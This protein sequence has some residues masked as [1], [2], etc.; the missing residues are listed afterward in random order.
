[1][2]KILSTLI[3]ILVYNNVFATVRT[4]SN[5]SN[6]LGQ[7]PSLTTAIGASL[8]GDTIYLSGSPLLYSAS[9][10]AKNVTIIGTGFNP[11]KQNPIVS[12]IGTISI[13]TGIVKFLGLEIDSLKFT[14]ATG[15][16][17]VH[18]SLL[19]N[20]YFV[21]DNRIKIFGSVI[22]NSFILNSNA[23]ECDIYTSVI[24]PQ[25][26]LINTSNATFDVYNSLFLFNGK[27]VAATGVYKSSNDYKS[28]IFYGAIPE[29]DG[30]T[31]NLVGQGDFRYN[32]SY[33]NSFTDDDGNNIVANP[34]FVNVASPPLAFNFNHNFHLQA[35]SPALLN[36]DINGNQ[37]GIYS[38]FWADY[39]YRDNGIPPIPSI[40]TMSITPTT[41]LSGQSIQV[42]FS[43]KVNQ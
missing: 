3:I 28:C 10:V 43:S 6:V 32:V 5:N 12:R 26:Q 14:S 9:N 40:Q 1:M 25:V 35:S 15:E 23:F 11:Q 20:G 4:V 39:L 41:V 37:R 34:L 8:N 21:Y 27:F 31:P 36:V 38:T 2:K 22:K 30:G 13:S 24:Y 16:C 29:V 19:N 7:Y 42:N 18:N 33:P 17:E